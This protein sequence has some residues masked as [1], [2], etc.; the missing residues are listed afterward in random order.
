MRRALIAAA[1]GISGWAGLIHAV[2][3]PSHLA[4]WWGYGV[5]FIAAASAQLAFAWVLVARLPRRLPQTP[6]WTVGRLAWNRLLLAGIAANSVIVAVYVLVHTVGAPLGP[7]AGEVEATT[8]SGVLATVLEATLIAVLVLLLRQQGPLRIESAEGSLRPD[9]PAAGTW[10]SWAA[11]VVALSAFVA[12]SVADAMPA[13]MAAQ[14]GGMGPGSALVLGQN[15]RVAAMA[16]GGIA[17]VGIARMRGSTAPFLPGAIALQLGVISI[18]LN[19][20][21]GVTWFVAAEVLVGF[22]LGA[23]LTAWLLTVASQDEPKRSWALAMLLIGTVAARGL[24]GVLE[25]GGI[26]VLTIMA[27][28]VLVAAALLDRWGKRHML[29]FEWRR[30]EAG[31]TATLVGC[32]GI[33]MVLAG[34]DSSGITA[35]MIAGPLGV[36][37]LSTLDLWRA[38]LTIAGAGLLTGAVVHV[39]R[40]AASGRSLGRPAAI[41]LVSLVFSGVTA[42]ATLSA[43]VAFVMPGERTFH[44]ISI[45]TVVGATA[46]IA[47]S[48][49]M[50]S[51]RRPSATPAVAAVLLAGV[52]LSALLSQGTD[53]LDLGSFVVLAVLG[54]LA[55]GMVLHDLWRLVLG[56]HPPRRPLMVA[57][58]VAGTAFG[59]SL[60]AS[61]ARGEALAFRASPSLPASAM[62]LVLLAASIILVAYASRIDRGAA[63]ADPGR[64]QQS[65][66]P[67]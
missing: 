5:F 28:A 44:P 27:G 6:S 33:F 26:L 61:L 50:I 54:G 1:A 29:A 41:A 46:G 51:T 23:S 55:A 53:G 24:S 31:A 40:R 15:A 58:A 36:A 30:W 10:T 42:L 17:L 65:A 38:V 52:A 3:T 57:I 62:G 35:M 9:R 12:G 59:S 67:G 60:G 34:A 49:W 63:Q 32:A 47:L 64:A 14:E 16:G 8:R 2:E 18:L 11:A 48:A 19:E 43:P 20:H 13:V 22:G 7:G 39:G 21:E 45:A 56:D 4:D 66:E 37:D 25:H